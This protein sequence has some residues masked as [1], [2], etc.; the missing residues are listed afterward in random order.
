MIAISWH[1]E[2][3]AKTSHH[4]Q[5]SAK[6]LAA[7]IALT[8]IMKWGK[9]EL[10]R[11]CTCKD[12]LAQRVGD[13]RDWKKEAEV[14]MKL[15]KQARPF[16]IDSTMEY[17]LGVKD[18]L[19]KDAMEEKLERVMKETYGYNPHIPAEEDDDNAQ[20]LAEG[21]QLPVKERV[22]AVHS[23]DSTDTSLATPEQTMQ[24]EEVLPAAIANLMDLDETPMNAIAPMQARGKPVQR[25]TWEEESDDEDDDDCLLITT[26]SEFIPVPDKSALTDVARRSLIIVPLVPYLITFTVQQKYL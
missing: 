25:A 3:L 19:K 6:Q 10:E 7:K 18:E 24:I 26:S 13:I 21:A 23:N 4:S 5:A 20:P 22:Q 12:D 14:T 2:E 9:S 16:D 17:D 8:T 1:G 11:I 15:P